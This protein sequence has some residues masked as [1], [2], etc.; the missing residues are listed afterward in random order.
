MRV[1][2]LNRTGRF[3]GMNLQQ[4][5]KL[6]EDGELQ[7]VYVGGEPAVSLDSAFALAD[8]WQEQNR[9]PPVATP[10]GWN[11]THGQDYTGTL[12]PDLVAGRQKA[13]PAPAEASVQPRDAPTNGSALVAHNA[14]FDKAFLSAEF[15]RVS[16]GSVFDPP[17][18]IDTMSLPGGKTSLDQLCRIIF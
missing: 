18:I 3:L 17:E 4:V 13:R 9:R 5:K 16:G 2:S 7:L 15:A 10:P 14:K 6:I 8:K 11:Q 1:F 12:D